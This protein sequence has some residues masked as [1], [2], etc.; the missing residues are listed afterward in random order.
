MGHLVGEKEVVQ[1]GGGKGE[2]QVVA[3]KAAG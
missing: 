3:L 1:E 2:D